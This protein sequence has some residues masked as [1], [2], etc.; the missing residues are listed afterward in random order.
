MQTTVF[1]NYLKDIKETMDMPNLAG[2]IHQLITTK[3]SATIPAEF[4]H[5]LSGS[6]LEARAN[7]KKLISNPAIENI[8]QKLNISDTFKHAMLIQMIT[9]IENANDYNQIQNNMKN[10]KMFM[11]LEISL[12]YILRLH[13][14]L[15]TM[16]IKENI[17]KIGNEEKK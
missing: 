17:P 10:F 11:E 3:G 15:E 7:Y 8:M 1:I 9:A 4:K 14:T 12:T 2:S 16:L 13:S 6:L 5:N